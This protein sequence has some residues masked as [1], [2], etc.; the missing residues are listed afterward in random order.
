MPLSS[1]LLLARMP[2]KAR[3][4]ALVD[5]IFAVAMTLLVLDIRLPEGVRLGSNA[6]L[7]EHLGSI[8]AAFWVYVLSFGVLAMFWAGHN[9]QFH[10][11]QR[12]DRSLLWTNFGFLLL[13]T[14]VPFTTNL[15]SSHSNLS[16]AVA[17]YAANLLLLCAVL[18]L[19]VRHLRR[20]QH[21]ATAELTASLGA[22][23][24][25]RLG[26]FC[27][28]AAGAIAVAQVS[29]GWGMR[30]F[31]LL[32]VIHFLPHPNERTAQSSP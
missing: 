12:L 32:A 28:V 10:L 15:V 14:M 22:H 27:I 30:T 17:L 3:L 6:Q 29:P 7:L 19:H 5:G 24:E 16:I 21:L 2:S 4:E 11:L 13:T 25:R 23:I 1:P 8:A 20:H 31:I 9:F 26:L 18:W